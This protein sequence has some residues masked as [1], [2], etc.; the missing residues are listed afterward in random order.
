MSARER[1]NIGPII[2]VIVVAIVV[3]ILPVLIRH[4][5]VSAQMA[6]INAQVTIGDPKTDLGSNRESAMYRWPDS[7]VPRTAERLR[8]LT[9]VAIAASTYVAQGA[10]NGHAP[11]NADEITK[12]ITNRQLIPSEWLTTQPSVLQTAHGTVYI[13]Y[14]PTTLTIE[15]ISMP[16]TL[17]DG[18]A[19][20]L[21]IPDGDNTAVGP[22]YFESMQLHGIIY[23][24]PFATV[25]EVIS[26]GWRERLLRLANSQN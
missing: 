1:G 11:K 19:L 6:T 22:R 4:R 21:R 20:L 10:I 2:C 18:P 15:V 9:A 5:R 12:G 3:L 26:A 16:S 23:P 8:D 13:R 17:T 7:E 14:S 25:P 24:S